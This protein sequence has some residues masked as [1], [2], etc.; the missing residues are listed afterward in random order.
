MDM[1]KRDADLVHELGLQK[2]YLTW[3]RSFPNIGQELP[4]CEKNPV[5][6]S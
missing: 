6:G 5:A 4:Y 1:A 2:L 3:R